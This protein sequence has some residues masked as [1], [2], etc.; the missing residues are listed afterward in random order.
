MQTDPQRAALFPVPFQRCI[1]RF[2]LQKENVPKTGGHQQNSVTERYRGCSRRIAENPDCGGQQR[3]YRHSRQIFLPEQ[4]SR[5]SGI[6]QEQSDRAGAMERLPILSAGQHDRR[7]GGTEIHTDRS[8]FRCA[9]ADLRKQIQQRAHRLFPMPEREA[10]GEFLQDHNRPWSAFAHHP[11]LLGGAAFRADA[12]AGGKV[13]INR[14]ETPLIRRQ[15][16]RGPNRNGRNILGKKGKEVCRLIGSP[17]PEG[18]T[19]L[20][21]QRS[22]DGAVFQPGEGQHLMLNEGAALR[23]AAQRGG[24]SRLKRRE[25]RIG[26][27]DGFSAGIRSDK[28]GENTLGAEN[29]IPDY[30]LVSG[31]KHGQP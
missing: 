3:G 21:R 15:G 4:I 30:I 12:E 7:G 23:R 31:R 5:D 14:I 19:T 28:G 22:L 11:G 10:G 27:R 20:Q 25:H 13:C 16:N 18:K 2:F 8:L 26:S 1:D 29:H 24:K 9:Q 6:G 17:H